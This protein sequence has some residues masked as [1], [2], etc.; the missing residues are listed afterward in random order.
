MDH[1][2]IEGGTTTLHFVDDQTRVLKKGTAP[3]I[4]IRSRKA[5]L[6]D[7]SRVLRPGIDV[8]VLVSSSQK[9]NNPGKMCPE[10]VSDLLNL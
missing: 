7:C 1:I 4:R 2:K 10:P 5:T 8:C 9:S 3:D 6:S